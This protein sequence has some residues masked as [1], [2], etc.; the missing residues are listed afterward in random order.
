[1]L[2]FLVKLYDVEFGVI[3]GVFEMF[4]EYIKVLLDKGNDIVRLIK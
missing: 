1:M 4:L 3:E 2:F